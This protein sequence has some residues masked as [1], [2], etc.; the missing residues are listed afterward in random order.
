VL[1]EGEDEDRLVARDEVHRCDPEGEE[2]VEVDAAEIRA[3]P[4]GAVEAVGVGHVRVE[5]G[6]DD[7]DSGA[8]HAGLRASVARRRCV[9]DLVQGRPQHEQA[10]DHQQEQGVVDE[11]ARALRDAVDEEE[12]DVEGDE[13]RDGGR[14]DGGEEE[15]IEERRDRVDN[16]GWNDGDPKLER[17]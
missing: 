6:P 11:L 8:H 7:V 15:R 10:E 1:E 9:P 16:P 13:P 2:R 4:S 12:P 3:Q 14:D 5:G 17:E